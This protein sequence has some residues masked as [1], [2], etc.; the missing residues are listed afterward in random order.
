[1]TLVT[2]VLTNRSCAIHG[3]TVVFGLI[4]WVITG[5]HQWNEPVMDRRFVKQFQ[6]LHI[7]GSNA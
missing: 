5:R 6:A 4:F 2:T 1:M 3:R 7:R